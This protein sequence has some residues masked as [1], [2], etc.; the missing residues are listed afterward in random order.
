MDKMYSLK[1]ES[2]LCNFGNFGKV[3]KNIYRRGDMF[4][5]D[6]KCFYIFEK[7]LTKICAL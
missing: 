2:Y 6:E 4:F 3:F 7:I 5:E 1:R